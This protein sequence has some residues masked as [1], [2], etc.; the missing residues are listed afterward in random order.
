M[1]KPLDEMTPEELR[2]ERIWQE[3]HFLELVAHL[4]D[5]KSATTWYSRLWQKWGEIV[6]IAVK[7]FVGTFMYALIVSVVFKLF[8][9]VLAGM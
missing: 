7:I 5:Q 9:V 8:V 4:E 2:A 1:R 3:C 6:G